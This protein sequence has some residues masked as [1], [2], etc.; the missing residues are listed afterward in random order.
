MV[1]VSARSV[2]D[3]IR[4]READAALF[5]EVKEGRIAVAKA[6]RRVRQARRRAELPASPP[7]PQGPF[8]LVY[9]DPPWQLGG[10]PESANAPENHYAT[11]PLETIRG[12]HLPAAEQAVLF[13]WRA[14]GILPQALE[15][16]AAWGF[17]CRSNAAWVKPSI[18]LDSRVRYR[19]EL[20]LIGRR[21]R[22]PAPE[23]ELRPDSVITSARGTH[24]Q[25]PALVYELI[26]RMYPAA[27][28]LELFARKPPPGWAAYGNELPT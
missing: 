10:D 2:Q 25:K 28:K 21:G 12:L 20:L 7:M 14:C 17:E 23:R 19:H 13:L 11:M 24:S 6:A 22:F 8:Q 16:M 26:E 5:R 3:E 15:M 18:G 4:V 1:D 27:S 9:A